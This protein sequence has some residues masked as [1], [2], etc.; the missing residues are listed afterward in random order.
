MKN[1]DAVKFKW[2]FRNYQQS[3]L[4]N[5]AKFLKD[6]RINIVAAPGSGKTILGLELIK[7]LGS[8]CIMFSPTTTIKQQWAD[9]FEEAYLPEGEKIDDYVSFDLN[10]IKLLNSITYQALHSAIDKVAVE[11]EEENLNYSNIDLFK[12]MNEKNIK[13]ICLD[14][15]HHLQN[16]WQKALEKF[17]KGLSSDVK[18]IS[19]TATPPYDATPAEWQRYISVCGEIDDEIFVPELV[20]QKNLCPHQDYILFNYPTESEVESFK[21]HRLSSYKAI[22]EIANLEFI[23]NLNEKIEDIYKNLNEHF[24]KNHNAIA[25]VFIFL[26][27]CNKKINNGIYQK[28]AK[29]GDIPVLTLKY[30]EEALLFMVE[31][32]YLTSVEE[33]EIL[34][35]I[36]KKYSLYHRKKVQ[37]DLT[38]KLRKTLVSSCGKLKSIS[39]IVDSESKVLKEN[40]RMLVLTDYI[41]KESSANIGTTNEIDNI[42][43]VSI[44][45]EIRRKGNQVRVGCLSGSLVILPNDVAQKLTKNYKLPENFFRV[46]PFKNTNYSAYNFKGTNRDKV[47]IISKLFEDG[48]INVLVGTQSLL[49]EGWDSPCINSLILASY[50]GSF[51]LSNQ[52]RGRAIRIY[53]KD[54]NKTANIWH[55]VTIEPEYK[56]S[57][58]ELQNN[59]VGAIID[60]KNDNT[61]KNEDKNAIPDDKKSEIKENEND[62][63]NN[64]KNEDK[65]NF[66]SQE[67]KIIGNEK[68][69]V[70]S[71][72]ETLSRRFNCFV[73]PNYKTNKIESGIERITFIKPPYSEEGIADINSKMLAKAEDRKGLIDSW[74]I[75]KKTNR[76]TVVENTISSNLKVPVLTFYN[77]FGLIFSL[78]LTIAGVVAIFVL[79]DLNLFKFFKFVLIAVCGIVSLYMLIQTFKFI[80]FMFTHRSAKSSIYSICVAVLKTFKSLDK[81]EDKAKLNVRE[82]ESKQNVFVSLKKSSLYEQ[83]IFNNALK[84]MLS[85]IDKPK[86][87][88][89]KKRLIKFYAYKYSFACPTEFEKNANTANLFKSYLKKSLGE[90]DFKFVHNEQ[91]RKLLVKCLRKSYIT[92]NYKDILKRNKVEDED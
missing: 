90:L 54:A 6:G 76:K 85:V 58:E 5:S 1:F 48:L 3:V 56:F 46:E 84:E 63:I 62:K 44:F 66:I 69:I 60:P 40:L 78:L 4:D 53:K 31:D 43:V 16:E 17:I 37:L 30:A 42:S 20:K 77:I 10:N 55:L 38:D 9:R 36:L 82:D 89:I 13:T 23:N 33:K 67:I 18:V 28:L 19:L 92:R 70:S 29:G 14:E 41:K 83:N 8:P 7:R 59:V 22:S 74:Q 61:N 68:E 86:Y 24:Y 39:T 79:M 27:H 32:I 45:E 72:Y 57:P 65:N 21:S 80:K 34:I 35:N 50:V 49:G 91:G 52:M 64:K 47:N 73:G 87:L 71:D 51:M 11:G 75:D 25:S 81:I 12:L 26:K 15:A 88:I 2:T